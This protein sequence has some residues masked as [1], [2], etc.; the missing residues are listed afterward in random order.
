MRLT[1]IACMNDE[2]YYIK[3]SQKITDGQILD[4]L[5]QYE[6]IDESPE[7]LAKVKEALEIIRYKRV[8]IRALEQCVKN[9]FLYPSL[10]QEEQDL[11]KEVLL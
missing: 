6:D 1:D 3:D 2:F 5:G 10:A 9:N 8:S 11:L 4:K 7:H